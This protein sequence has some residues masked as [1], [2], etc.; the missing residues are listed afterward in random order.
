MATPWGVEP[1][2]EKIS[3]K[4]SKEKKL[5]IIEFCARSST[6]DCNLQYYRAH[7]A[8]CIAMYAVPNS[9]IQAQE[10]VYTLECVWQG[11]LIYNKQTKPV[12][13]GVQSL[14]V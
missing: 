5:L 3:R 1:T 2:A 10:P 12:C 11:L 14:F 6:I 4:K 13:S 7:R 9:G 8:I